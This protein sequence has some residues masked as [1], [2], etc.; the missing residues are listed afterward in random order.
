PPPP[1]EPC[2][3]GASPDYVRT[4]TADGLPFFENFYAGGVRSI[5]GFRDN[6]LGPRAAPFG[7]PFTQPIGG[8]IKTIGQ[9][10]LIFPTLLDTPS[11]RVSAFLDFGNVFGN[12]EGFDVGQF[13]ASTGVALLWRAPVGPIS[14]SYAFPLR[15]QDGDEIE[16]LQFTFG[17]GF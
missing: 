8:A 7:S 13:R 16:R 2:I 10:E 1:S 17:G 4:I 6:S 5:R 9:V 3:P 15:K 14:I 11:A 12:N